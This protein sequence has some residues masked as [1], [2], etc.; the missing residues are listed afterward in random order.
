MSIP[1][2]IRNSR[3]MGA[4]VAFLVIGT[5]AGFFLGRLTAPASEE[6]TSKSSGQG[7]SSS[8]IAKSKQALLESDVDSEDEGDQDLKS[9][10]GHREEC[11]LILVVRTDLGMTKGSPKTIISLVIPANI[12]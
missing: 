6:I 1:L 5:V 3:A 10:E 9:F 11:K 4:A 8:S 12:R 7:Q 2:Q